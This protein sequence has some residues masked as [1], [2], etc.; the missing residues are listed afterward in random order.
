MDLTASDIGDYVKN[1]QQA[2]E[3]KVKLPP[4]YSIVWSG[5]YEYMERAK[6]RLTVVVPM[7]LADHLSAAVLQLQERHRRA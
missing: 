3:Q 4:G 2:V 6:Q 1:A 7:T 5:Q